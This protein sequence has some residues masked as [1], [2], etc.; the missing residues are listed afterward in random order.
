MS[1]AVCKAL[2][3]M[4][5]GVRV[6]VPA[7]HLS[8]CNT[9]SLENMALQKSKFGLCLYGG[10]DLELFCREN[11]NRVPFLCNYLNLTSY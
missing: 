1:A 5:K 11:G 3:F 6:H 7:Y 9:I 4:N 8:P 2:A 10:V